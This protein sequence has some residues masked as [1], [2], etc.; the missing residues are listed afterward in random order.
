MKKT[1]LALAL[2]SAATA[3]MAQPTSPFY[4]EGKL[5]HSRL[6]TPDFKKTGV[7]VTGGYMFTPDMGAEV[8]YGYFGKKDGTTYQGPSAG[9]V[10]LFDLGDN[11]T[12]RT[13]AGVAHIKSSGDSSDSWT[14]LYAGLGLEYALT[15]NASL[16]FDYRYMK[17]NGGNA[18][19]IGLGVKW[20]F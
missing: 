20:A 8:S 10:G 17:I 15:Q 7:E 2:V 14:R 19:N 4:V 13:K 12:L 11:L 1:L 9:L 6:T 18:H 5:S 3:T 16:V